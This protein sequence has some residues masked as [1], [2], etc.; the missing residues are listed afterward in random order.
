MEVEEP[1]IVTGAL[2]ADRDMGPDLVSFH[3]KHLSVHPAI[4]PSIHPHTHTGTP[5]SIQGSSDSQWQ[6][7]EE[8]HVQTDW[9]RDGGE[10]GIF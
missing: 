5:L 7:A 10:N 9:E 6:P 2:C 3:P 8:G 1:L 4:R